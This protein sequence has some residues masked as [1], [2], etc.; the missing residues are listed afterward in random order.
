[1]YRLSRWRL[2]VTKKC[3]SIPTF[4]SRFPPPL[5]GEGQG[6]GNSNGILTNEYESKQCLLTFVLISN[7]P[8]GIA[9]SVRV[10]VPKA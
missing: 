3:V 7:Y 4:R 6:G 8:T 10:R 5:K 9:R 1:M 2:Y